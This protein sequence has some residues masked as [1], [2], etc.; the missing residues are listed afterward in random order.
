MSAPSSLDKAMQREVVK[1]MSIMIVIIAVAVA[2]V[3]YKAN[4]SGTPMKPVFGKAA[5]NAP[6]AALF[7]PIPMLL[8][9][10]RAMPTIKIAP[11]K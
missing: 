4:K 5:T 7:Q 9:I 11:R 10:Y 6:N 1:I 8:D 3:P 2:G